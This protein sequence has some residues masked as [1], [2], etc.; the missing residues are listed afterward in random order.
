MVDT[1]HPILTKQLCVLFCN[2]TKE[3]H[4][5]ESFKMMLCRVMNTI[6]CLDTAISRVHNLLFTYRRATTNQPY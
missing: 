1:L 4:T 3:E 6:D 2:V 5:N